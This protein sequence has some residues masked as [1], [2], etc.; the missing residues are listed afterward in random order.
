[1]DEGREV[2]GHN[3]VIHA[4]KRMQPKVQKIQKRNQGNKNH[5]SWVKARYTQC[6]QFKIMLNTNVS[7]EDIK[8]VLDLPEN[9]DLPTHF[10]PD[11]IPTLTRE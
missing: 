3:A 4:V 7:K 5:K 6:L 1:M 2:V 8:K 11:K 10:D 9:E